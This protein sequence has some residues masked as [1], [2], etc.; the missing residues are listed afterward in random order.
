MLPNSIPL[1]LVLVLACALAQP[2]QRLCLCFSSRT[3]SI[4]FVEIDYWER[5]LFETP[6]YVVNV[7]ERAEDLRI[8]QE[9]LLL[10]ARDYNRW[11]PFLTEA[12]LHATSCPF[13]VFYL[14]HDIVHFLQYTSFIFCPSQKKKKRFPVLSHVALRLFL[15]LAVLSSIFRV[16]SKTTGPLPPHQALGPCILLA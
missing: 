12:L 4:L 16:Q 8:L 3:L 2:P 6:H 10:V 5:L 1:E 13:F 14:P 7:A 9:N 11:G 15:S